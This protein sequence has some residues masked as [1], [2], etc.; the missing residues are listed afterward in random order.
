MK[1]GHES[2]V[3]GVLWVELCTPP[4]CYVQ[5]PTPRT[6]E[7]TFR[8]WGLYRDDLGGVG[9]WV[10]LIRCDRHSHRRGTLD[11]GTQVESH[12]DSQLASETDPPSS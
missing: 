9:S 2:S 10:A 7:V 11:T 3:L 5:I 6:S 8:R 4:H 1:W 12:E